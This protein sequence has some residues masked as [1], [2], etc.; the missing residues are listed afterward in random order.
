M[1]LP[2][3]AL[4]IITGVLNGW[5]AS[6][7]ST[8]TADIVREELVDSKV[9]FEFLAL[10]SHFCWSADRKMLRWLEIMISRPEKLYPGPRALFLVGKSLGAVHLIERVLP[11]VSLLPFCPPIFIFTVD[12]NEPRRWD[13][14]PNL[15]SE[16]LP[17]V[18]RVRHAINVYV[19]SPDK[20]RQC[21]ARLRPMGSNTDDNIEN[22][23]VSDRLGY[24]HYS[25]VG[26][27]IVRNALRN[28]IGE[29][30]DCLSGKTLSNAC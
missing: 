6:S 22:L 16:G 18:A 15:N 13:L 8:R 25:I 1:V 26:S 28:M 19:M 10:K 4:T 20:Q 24:D 30:K 9:K 14:T 21:G 12:P 2:M 23:P 3:T 7:R 29:I 27:E 17:V 5:S 11:Q